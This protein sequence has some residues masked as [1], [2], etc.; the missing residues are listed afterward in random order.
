MKLRKKLLITST[1]IVILTVPL[2][3]CSFSDGI[4]FKF[5]YPF[6][7]FTL[8]DVPIKDNE[9]LLMRMNVNVFTFIFDVLIVYWLLTLVTLIIN[10][11]YN[12]W[13]RKS[14]L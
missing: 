3:P 4:R 7:Y 13:P 11:I 10:S 6:S 12:Y 14:K 2:L 5:G 9:I 1:V 8:F